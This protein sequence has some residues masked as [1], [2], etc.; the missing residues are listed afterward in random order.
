LLSQEIAQCNPLADSPSQLELRIMQSQQLAASL[1]FTLCRSSSQPCLPDMP[2]C[3][4]HSYGIYSPSLPEEIAQSFPSV[5]HVCV[6]SFPE[7]AL[8]SLTYFLPCVLLV[9]RYFMCS[10]VSMASKRTG[11]QD[12][13]GNA[14]RATVEQVS[15]SLSIYE[16]TKLYLDKDIKLKWQ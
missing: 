15:S 8:I 12:T 2:Y 13:N 10:Y 11:S 4:F 7:V 1:D 3:L 16:D 5:S 14:A 6:V 9:S